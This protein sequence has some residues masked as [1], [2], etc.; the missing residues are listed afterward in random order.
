MK[1]ICTL[2]LALIMILGLCACG[3]KTE[4]SPA[5]QEQPE[6]VVEAVEE[7]ALPEDPAAEPITVLTAQK[8]YSAEGAL[9]AELHYF[10]NE[11]GYIIR[12]EKDG[13]AET[14]EYDEEGNCTH[15]CIDGTTEDILGMVQG[16][17]YIYTS[18][19]NI[20]SYPGTLPGTL[21][22]VNPR[23]NVIDEDGIWENQNTDRAPKYA[24]AKYTFDE[25]GYSTDIVTY[26]YEG[27]ILGTATCEW[28]TI[29]PQS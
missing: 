22:D 27:E 11:N 15:T 1:R 4:E 14:W 28:E 10:Y 8:V 29:I 21:E 3:Q 18:Y 25:A 12:M 26:G 9:V 19:N 7:T 6:Q 23:L 13:T 2:A 16:T 20:Y 17:Y 5:V 24:Y